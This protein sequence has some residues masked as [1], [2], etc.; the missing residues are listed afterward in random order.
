MTPSEF[1]PAPWARLIP[2][3]KDSAM[4]KSVLIFA[5]ASFVFAGALPST[6][7]AQVK[8]DGAR[9]FAHTAYL[10]S[11]EFQGRKSGTPEY[12][13]A[14]EYVAATQAN[15]TARTTRRRASKAQARE[16]LPRQRQ[17]AILPRE[18]NVLRTDAAHGP[19]K[20]GHV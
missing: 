4:K 18:Q 20:H 2:Q 1:P 9:A 10:A 8:P 16:A 3:A 5:A 14:A 17:L 15:H 11:D 7:S 13:K 12:R 6:T 19:A